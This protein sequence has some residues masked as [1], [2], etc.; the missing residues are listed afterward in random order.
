[1]VSDGLGIAMGQRRL[2]WACHAVAVAAMCS[3][4]AVA[5]ADPTAADRDTARS[6]MSEGR[7]FRDKGDLKSALKSFSE[8]DAIMHVPTTG[9]EV[10]RTQAALGRLVEAK[11]TALRVARS[12]EKPVDPAPFRQARAAAAAF[13]DDLEAR[14]PAVTIVVR[15]TDGATAQVTIDEASVRPEVLVQP[16]RL[17]P[18]HH[19]IAAKAGGVDGK[20]EIDLTERDRREVTLDLSPAPSAAP[21]PRDMPL[22]RASDELS[23]EPSRSRSPLSKALVFGGFGLAAVGAVAGTVAGVLSVTKTNDIKSSTGCSGSVCGPTEY[24]D[25]SSARSAATISTLSFVAAGVGVVAG[26][27]GLLSGGSSAAPGP[28]K[29]ARSAGASRLQPWIVVSSPTG[30]AGGYAAGLRGTF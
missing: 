18:G 28:E 15:A 21:R 13:S 23:T 7:A 24:N 11:E 17:D 1:M 14:I 5:S 26:V 8:A 3:V 20:Q 10:A 29:S 22:D 2:R 16:Q 4:S 25:I 6:L 19:V 9:L 27:V 30:G 12:V